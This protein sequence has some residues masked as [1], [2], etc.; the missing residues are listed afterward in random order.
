MLRVAASCLEEEKNKRP[1]MNQVVK[2]LMDFD[3]R[4]EK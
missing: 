3:E 2:D 4:D 1:T